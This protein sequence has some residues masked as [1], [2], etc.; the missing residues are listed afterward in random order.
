MGTKISNELTCNTHHLISLGQVVAAKHTA[1]HFYT[2]HFLKILS[3][4]V[5]F[6]LSPYLTTKYAIQHILYSVRCTVKLFVDDHKLY[7]AVV[8]VVYWYWTLEISFSY[9]MNVQYIAHMLLHKLLKQWRVNVLCNMCLHSC[10]KRQKL[11][12]DKY[13]Q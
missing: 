2:V 10:W 5:G 6:G 12:G 11:I 3:W 1:V 4:F 7:R 13:F 9:I 8:C